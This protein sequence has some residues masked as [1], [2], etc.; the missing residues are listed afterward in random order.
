[1]GE[2]LQ[3]P[4]N[5]AGSGQQE[6]VEQ[7]SAPSRRSRL[8]RPVREQTLDDIERLAGPEARR[9]AEEG[10]PPAAGEDDAP[11]W[12]VPGVDADEPAPLPTRTSKRA[13]NVAIAAL[14]RHDASEGE[15][16]AKL[17]AK[18]LPPE[19]VEAEVDRLRRTGL[20]DDAAFAARLVD[21]LRDRKGLGDQA[22]RSTLRGRLVPQDVIDAV[23]LE[24]AEDEETAEARLQEVADERARRLGSLAFDVAERRLT[25]YLMRKGYSGSAVRTAVR[26]ALEGAGIR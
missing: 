16:R 12:A 18:G 19:D 5:R 11:G 14:T 7:R 26:S 1:M 6:G 21:R 4:G 22:I 23:L 13:E 10:S 25:A 2:L 24:Q 15:I 3:F 8:P 20:L 9:R 17:V